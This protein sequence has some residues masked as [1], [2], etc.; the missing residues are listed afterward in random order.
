MK[1]VFGSAEAVFNAAYLSSAL[2]LAIVLLSGHPLS[3]VRL[4]SGM[5]ALVLVAGDAFHL[6]PRMIV[7]KTGREE[8][9]R[10]ALGRGKQITSITMSLFYVFLWQI[11]LLV[12]SPDGIIVWS[13]IVYILAA[14]RI[15]LCLL[16]QNM[17]EERFSPSGWGIW[18]NIPFF[19]Q[20]GAVAGL[21][22]LNRSIAPSLGLIW[23]AILLSFVFY[24][25][26]VFWSKKKPRIGMLMLPK[27]C[28]YLWMLAMCMSL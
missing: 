5:M 16:P 13:I 19:L 23:L 4:L 22:F 2:I 14:A 7:I 1:R 27:T 24:V 25:P 28:C 6:V 17:W 8:Q 10:Q 26:V 18:R 20:G 21:Y 3:H 12:F 15:I 9:M 11:G